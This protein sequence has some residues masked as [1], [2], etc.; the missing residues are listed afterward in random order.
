[1]TIF[2]VTPDPRGG[3]RV[4]REGSDHDEMVCDTRYE[5][6]EKAKELARANNPSRV[7]VLNRRGAVV[8]EQ[9]FDRH[10]SG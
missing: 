4:R 1:M 3:W 9:T 2:R 5:A 10:G 8:E 7:Q 6:F